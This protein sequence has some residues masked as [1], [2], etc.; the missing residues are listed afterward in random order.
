MPRPLFIKNMIAPCG[1]NCYL[2]IMYYGY[3][4]GGKK[5]KIKCIGC[6]AR[7][8]SCAFVKK[9]CELLTK[10]EVEY[11]YGCSIFPCE[12]LKKLDKRYKERYDMSMIENLKFIKKHGMKK[13]LTEQRK[14]YKCP[15][16]GGVI[17]V[18]DKKC[19]SCDSK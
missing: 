16:C 2:C 17:C 10:K 13:F 7:D 18:H 1:M 6:R 8:K 5:S 4:I 9:G 19:Y 14:K 11:C 3:V 12:K 15:D